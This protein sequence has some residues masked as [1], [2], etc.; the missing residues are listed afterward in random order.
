M[1]G[2]RALCRPTLSP[3]L[4]VCPAPPPPQDPTGDL[5]WDEDAAAQDVH[6]LTDETFDATLKKEKQALVMFYAPWCGHCKSLKPKWQALA[7]ELKAVRRGV[8]TSL[9]AALVS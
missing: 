2:G 8:R 6:H 7:T 4:T 3:A 9:A 5:P 1:R